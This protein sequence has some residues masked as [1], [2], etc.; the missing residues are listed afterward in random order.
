MPKKLKFKDNKKVGEIKISLR[1]GRGLA[2][3]QMKVAEKI[4]AT[5]RIFAKIKS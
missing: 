1:M 4:Q 2:K 5:K 3:A